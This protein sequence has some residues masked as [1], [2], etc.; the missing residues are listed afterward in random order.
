MGSITARGNNV[1]TGALT[2]ISSVIGTNVTSFTKEGLTPVTLSGTNTFTSGVTISGGALTV[3]SAGAL[4][5]TAGSQN[6]V[7]FGASAA[8]TAT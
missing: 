3:G 7:T 4:N 6:A 1:G 8:S 2:T 5:S